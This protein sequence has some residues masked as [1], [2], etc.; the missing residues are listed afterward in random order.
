M[1]YQYC[2]LCT[3]YEHNCIHGHDTKCNDSRCIMCESFT[4]YNHCG[5]VHPNNCMLWFIGVCDKI[6]DSLEDIKH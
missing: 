6:G 3:V 5:N 4:I 2:N 1:K